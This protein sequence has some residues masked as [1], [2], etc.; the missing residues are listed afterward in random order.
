MR[1]PRRRFI[2]AALALLVVLLVVRMART[3][4]PAASVATAAALSQPRP[5]AAA[6]AATVPGP[7]ARLRL[8]A[9]AG[10]RWVRVE[11][12]PAGAPLAHADPKFPARV[13]NT[14]KGVGWLSHDDHAIL[15][16]NAFVDTRSAEPLRVPEN[17][18]GARIDRKNLAAVLQVAFVALVSVL[19]R[20]AA[21]ADDGER[22]SREKIFD[23]FIER[24][25]FG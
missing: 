17:L 15:L 24:V 3:P 21:C 18:R 7:L 23:L 13:R 16:R 5:A 11:S 9:T 1:H 6:T 25:H 19:I 20:I 10:N 8:G 22:R 12:S 2:V 4:Q 14:T